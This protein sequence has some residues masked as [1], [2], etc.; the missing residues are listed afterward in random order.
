MNAQNAE[1]FVVT[2]DDHSRAAEDAML[3]GESARREARF[4][5]RIRDDN[6]LAGGQRESRQFDMRTEFAQQQFFD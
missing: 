4:L 1:R 5:P 6:R 3:L 2:R